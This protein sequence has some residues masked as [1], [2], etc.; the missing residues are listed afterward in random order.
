M[1]KSGTNGDKISLCAMA[2]M[3]NVEIVVISTLEEG[4]RV[5]ITPEYSTPYRTLVLGHFA[6]EH[7]CHYVVLE[8]DGHRF[9]ENSYVADTDPKNYE[10]DSDIRNDYTDVSNNQCKSIANLVSDSDHE[11][12]TDIENCCC[13]RYPT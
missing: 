2:N 1:S 4:R 13:A 12:E 5:I 11:R 8:G 10:S 6:E 7:G 9:V 3:F